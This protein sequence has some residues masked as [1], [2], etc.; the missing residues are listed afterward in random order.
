MCLLNAALFVGPIARDGTKTQPAQPHPV[1]TLLQTFQQ[2]NAEERL[3]SS[4]K[5]SI[6]AINAY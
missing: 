2:E 4:G 1:P 5:R 6:L 3:W